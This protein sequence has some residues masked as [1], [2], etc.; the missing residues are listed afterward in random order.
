M[1][2]FGSLLTGN[3]AQAVLGV[4]AVAFFAEDEVMLQQVGVVLHL[5]DAVQ[6][7]DDALLGEL[8]DLHAFRVEVVDGHGDGELHAS[9][10]VPSR[11]RRRL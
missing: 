8:H 11:L 6:L 3:R 4:Q 9:G 7:A 5:G 10:A 2:L 1:R